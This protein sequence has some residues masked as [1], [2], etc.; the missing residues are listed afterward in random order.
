MTFL[1]IKTEAANRLNLTSTESFTRL[2][3]Y[4]NMRYRRITSSLGLS[5]ARRMVGAFVSTVSGNNTVT[6]SLEKVEMVYTTAG[7]DRI[8]LQMPYEEFRIK[9]VEAPKSGD[10]TQ[11]AIISTTASTTTVGL[12][13]TPSSAITLKADGIANAA[14]MADGDT[15][16]IP[17]DFHDVLV[18]GAMAD[19]LFKMEKY[20]LSR[21]RE[22][23]FEM[24]LSDLRLFLAK[25]AYLSLAE[26][27]VPGGLVTV[28]R[29]RWQP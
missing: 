4:I 22:R 8:L 18:L 26:A 19:E 1:E 24:R 6:F 27:D 3:S 9:T 5:T 11:Y 21:D 17:A 14:T 7:K 2:G 25:S 28:V 20:D 16:A 23:E 12:Y 15:P 13:P 29:K 10:P